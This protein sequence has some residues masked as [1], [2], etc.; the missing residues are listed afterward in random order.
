MKRP[1]AGQAASQ[2]SQAGLVI[3][4]DMGMKQLPLAVQVLFEIIMWRYETRSTIM[5]T[6]D[7]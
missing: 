5:T 3:V 4:D 1:T 2:V 7:R 6:T